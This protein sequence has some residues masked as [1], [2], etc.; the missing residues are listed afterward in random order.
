MSDLEWRPRA[1]LDGDWGAAM[2]L[3][4]SI[5]GIGL[6]ASDGESETHAFLARNP[7]LNFVAEVAGRLVATVMAGND[8]R[9]GYIYHA[10]VAPAWRGR[11]IGKSLMALS[12]DGLTAAGL[13]KVSLY[14]KADNEMGK[15]FWEYSGWTRRDDLALYSHDL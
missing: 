4:K 13:H 12:L 14:C 2:E 3:W 7:G 1:F 8:G 6:S 9:R 15:A 5:P 10:C 11:G